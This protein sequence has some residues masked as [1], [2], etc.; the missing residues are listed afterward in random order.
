MTVIPIWK[1]K[2]VSERAIEDR[3]KTQI[4][5][6]LYRQGILQIGQREFTLLAKIE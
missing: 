3:R 2:K 5:F 6:Y 4:F 1:K